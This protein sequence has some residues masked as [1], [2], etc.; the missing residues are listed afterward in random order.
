LATDDVGRKLT[1]G[2]RFRQGVRPRFLQKTI[3][4]SGNVK[5]S[6]GDAL[7]TLAVSG[8]GLVR[9]ASLIVRVDI[10]ANRLVAVLEEFN[11][12]DIRL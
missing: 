8:A 6:D 2:D 1:N 9:V 11:P 7:R 4:P 3:Q 12:G 5:V 10:A